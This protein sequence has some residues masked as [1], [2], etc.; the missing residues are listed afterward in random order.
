M[1]GSVLGTPAY[2]APE[3]AQGEAVDERSDVY[4][5]GAILYTALTGAAPYSGESPEKILAAVIDGPP[6]PVG[7]RHR[8]VPPDLE[9]IVAKA[10]ARAPGDR[11]ANARELARELKRF[12]TGRLVAAHAYS[13]A[14]LFGRWVR[15]HRAA[16]AVG[17][18]AAIALTALGGVSVWN[19]VAE[20]DRA[21]RAELR[22]LSRADELAVAQARQ[23][24]DSPR[25][26][27]DLLTSLRP[28]SSQWS[29]A[30]LVAAEVASR[31]LPRAVELPFPA[32]PFDLSPDGERVAVTDRERTV[33]LVELGTGAHR[34]LGRHRGHINSVDFSPDGKVVATAS[35]DN[36]IALWSTESGE[37]LR[38]FTGHE[39]SVQSA[40]LSATGAYV[41]SSGFDQTSWLWSVK[42]T[43]HRKL[44]GLLRAASFSA[45]DRLV[46][47]IDTTR[48]DRVRV[49]DLETGRDRELALPGGEL[50]QAVISADGRRVAATASDGTIRLWELASGE[51]RVIGTHGA[52]ARGLAFTPDGEHLVSAGDRTVRV[53]PLSGSGGWSYQEHGEAA[54]TV[55]I[56]RG[57]ETIAA[58]GLE[59]EL[60]VIDIASRQGRRVLSRTGDVRFGPRGRRL[61]TIEGERL[62]LVPTT[63]RR[64]R[65]EAGSA[66]RRAAVA[67]DRVLAFGGPRLSLR[68][69]DLESGEHRDLEGHTAP[70]LHVAASP[71]GALIAS[72]DRRKKVRLFHRES[73]E[74]V[75]LPGRASLQLAFSPAGAHLAAPG[76]DGE[77][78]L[79]NLNSGELRSLAGHAGWIAWVAFSPDGRR[80]ASID[81]TGEVR[82]WSAAGNHNRLLGKAGAPLRRVAF[83]PAGDRV[84]AAGEAGA[85]LSW[86]VDGGE[87]EIDPSPQA[88]L[89]GGP[90]VGETV[91]EHGGWALDL[92]FSPDGKTLAVA[93]S[94]G[95]V[96]LVGPGRE[97]RR[98]TAGNEA[99]MAIAFSADGGSLLTAGA[100][101]EAVLWDVASGTSRVLTRDGGPLTF[102]GFARVGRTLL[103][104]GGGAAHAFPDA[105]PREP[106]ALA[107][108]VAEQLE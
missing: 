71:N 107:R 7:E 55:A 57:G 108:W 28:D 70:V 94:D 86:P 99:V 52:T 74:S 26:A 73:G 60:H 5:L 44:T 38:V 50:R 59:G 11:Y 2:M 46:T 64:K 20:R 75:E 63:P 14:E 58:R 49:H 4:S 36:T 78:R 17:A 48:R 22:A 101:G 42:G 6:V 69:W 89:S 25:E 3:Q 105:L 45:D 41:V 15:R 97:V 8:G 66:A 1:A 9:T 79:W 91:L 93:G 32:G 80:L 54:G 88:N 62:V 19:I 61:V 82:L 31:G 77:L 76:D 98:L 72:L 100:A 23:L 12:R 106:A 10:M 95:V 103:V 83:T 24:L 102:A 13:R 18:I 51:M 68:L 67:G 37:R 29:A 33:H 35:M 30:R 21:R 84:V 87:P 47:G 65:V 40:E 81:S 16:I 92:A 104:L 43:G 34:V 85:V 39:G 90:L 96:Q 53:W 27:L 56:S